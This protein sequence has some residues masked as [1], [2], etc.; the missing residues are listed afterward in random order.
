MIYTKTWSPRQKK[1]K[2]KKKKKT[3]EFMFMKHNALNRCEPRI[4]VIVKMGV[5][6]GGG[7]RVDVDEEFKVTVKMQRK[8]S[9][10]GGVRVHVN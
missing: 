7:V 4:E 3:L 1:K 6:P 8:K 5:R 10:G 2:K 9:R